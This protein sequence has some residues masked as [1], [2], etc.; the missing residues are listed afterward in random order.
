VVV[1]GQASSA[2]PVLGKVALALLSRRWGVG[3]ARRLRGTP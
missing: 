2:F 3:G 1:V